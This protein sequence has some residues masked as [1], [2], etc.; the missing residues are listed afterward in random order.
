MTSAAKRKT[1]AKK[2]P[3]TKKPAAKI[4]QNHAEHT[5]ARKLVVEQSKRDLIVDRSLLPLPKV[6]DLINDAKKRRWLEGYGH[7]G[8]KSEAHMYA[9]ISNTTFYLWT[10]ET[11]P[12][13]RYPEWTGKYYDHDFTLAVPIAYVAFQDRVEG[14]MRR[15]GIEGWE[16]PVFG[17]GEGRDA[18][19]EVVGTIRRYSDR[20]LELLGKKVNPL[21][22]DR[23]PEINVDARTQSVHNHAPVF[24]AKALSSEQRK[25]LLKMLELEDEKAKALEHQPQLEDT[26]HAT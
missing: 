21:F 6:D 9:G 4:Q 5:R 20:M 15:R 26:A 7:F 14:E 19:T 17:K 16:E 2:K 8:T 10:D 18:G 25:L 3:G 1:S 13:P 12:V 23:P 22:K 11:Y 24:D